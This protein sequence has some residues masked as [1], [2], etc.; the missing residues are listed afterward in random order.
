MADEK[1]YTELKVERKTIVEQVMDNLK[2]MIASGD[3]K[4]GDKLPSEPEL[5]RIFGVGRSTIREALKNFQYLGVLESKT[6]SGTF[7]LDKN[8]ISREALTWTFL[9]GK[10]EIEE[11]IELR[12]VLELRGY[13]NLIL[14][15]NATIHGEICD[16]LYE[17]LKIFRIYTEEKNIQEI[18]KIDY[19]FHGHIIEGSENKLFSDIYKTLEHFMLNE[20]YE[21]NI[22]YEDFEQVYI[23]HLRIYEHILSKDIT[24]ALQEFDKHIEGIRHKLKSKYV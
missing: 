7:L 19:K 11:F 8:N 14:L 21:T 5:A 2:R 12:Q 3:L 10:T 24:K 18:C 4:P 22:L 23:D 13:Q 1:L 9:L 6:G 17:D 16:K 20:I 15:S